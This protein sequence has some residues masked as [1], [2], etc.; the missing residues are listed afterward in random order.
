MMA[1]AAS[2]PLSTPSISLGFVPFSAGCKYLF[3]VLLRFFF[4]SP[5]SGSGSD[6]ASSSSESCVVF[7]VLFWDRSARHFFSNSSSR[8]FSL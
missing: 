5:A 2:I 7:F 4:G 8:S 6:S 3:L 1:N